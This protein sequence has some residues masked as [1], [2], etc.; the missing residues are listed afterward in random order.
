MDLLTKILTGIRLSELNTEDYD[1][2]TVNLNST[3][4]A[5]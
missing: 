3:H 4:K 5:L 2:E 1:C